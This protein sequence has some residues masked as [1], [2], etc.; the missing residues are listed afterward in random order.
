[1]A[2]V[3]EAVIHF[4]LHVQQKFF[5]AA[6]LGCDRIGTDFKP[7]CRLTLRPQV[8]CPSLGQ[9]RAVTEAT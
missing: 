1:M 3:I 9:V 4:P 2:A 5:K 7:D 8:G 6:A